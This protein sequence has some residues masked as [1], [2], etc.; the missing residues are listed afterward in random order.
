MEYENGTAQV[1]PEA[2]DTTPLATETPSVTEPHVAPGEGE[3]TPSATE[4]EQA[5]PYNRFK[6][7]NDA[8]K[9]A[10][11]Q[12]QLLANQLRMMQ[13]QQMQPAQ[14]RQPDLAAEL[15][16]TQ[17]DLY[18]EDGIQKLLGGVNQLVQRQVQ[19]AQQQMSQQ[20][21][22]AAHPDFGELVGT[23]SGGQFIPSETWRQIQRQNPTLAQAIE[24]S[25]QAPVLAYEYAKSYRATQPSAAQRIVAQAKQMAAP[26]GPAPP[27]ITQA[28]GSGSMDKVSQI[29]NMTQ[30]QFTAWKEQIK[31]RGGVQ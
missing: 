4:T 7:V 24:S 8:K 3:T 19:A 5:V 12:A 28:V 11:D 14:Q 17:D 30:D 16:I 31:A 25:P 21:Y 23:S 6:E 18:T 10:E 1:V 27:S 26:S 20:Q 15:G 2:G 29:H 9:A 13:Q 22:F